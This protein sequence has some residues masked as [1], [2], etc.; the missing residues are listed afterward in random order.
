[1]RSVG[2]IIESEGGTGPSSKDATSRPGGRDVLEGVEAPGE[3]RV[4]L[5]GRDI[6]ELGLLK[7]NNIRGS[8]QKF[9]QHRTTFDCITKPSYIPV[10]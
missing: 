3:E 4:E 6:I 7:K 5:Q 8:R 2:N 9:G 10:T 1:M